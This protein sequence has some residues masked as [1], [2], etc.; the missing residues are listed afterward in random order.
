MPTPSPILAPVLSLFDGAGTEL[1]VLVAVEA[2]AVAVGKADTNLLHDIAKA[3]SDHIVAI[4]LHRLD[5]V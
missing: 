1:A 2:L 4:S 5:E 3:K